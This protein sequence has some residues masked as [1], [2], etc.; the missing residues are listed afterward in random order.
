MKRPKYLHDMEVM[1]TLGDPYRLE[2]VRRLMVRPATL[3]QLGD[4]MGLHPAKVRYHLKKLEAVN[5]VAFVSS[6]EVRGFVEKY[7]SATAQAYFLNQ[8]I[9]PHYDPENTVIFLGSHDPALE[10]L[11]EY[12]ENAGTGIKLVAIPI[13]S[14]DGLIALRQ[15]FCQMTGCHLYDPEDGVYNSSYVRH[16]FPGQPMHLV[17][18]AYRLQGLLVPQGNP[19]HIQGVGD[20]VRDDV[21]VVNRKPGSGTRLWLDQQLKSIGISSDEIFG[22]DHEVST[23][24]AVAEVVKEGEADVGLA[25]FAAARQNRLDFIPLFEERFDFVIPADDFQNELLLPILDHLNSS[26]FKREFTQLG[27]YDS[28]DTGKETHIE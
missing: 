2:I 19:K 11:S 26:Q 16:F 12:L 28:H 7:Y 24:S 20:L 8:V 22:Y 25:V 18:L 10:L 17:T 4:L 27:G 13:G 14:L 23:H 15:G 5:L 6:R 1:K 3:S 21:S 9:L